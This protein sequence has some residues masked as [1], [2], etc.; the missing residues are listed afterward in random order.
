MNY[1]ARGVR[2]V[3]SFAE[4]TTE[5]IGWIMSELKSESKRKRFNYFN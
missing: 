5:K 4:D 3:S 1:C 2:R